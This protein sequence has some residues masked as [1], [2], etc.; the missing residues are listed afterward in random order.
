MFTGTIRRGAVFLPVIWLTG[1]Q[2]PP[3]V[4][5][6]PT[7]A[8]VAP[9]LQGECN[10]C[11]GATAMVTGSMG[12]ATYRFD[13]YDMSDALCG[14]AAAAMDV[15]ALAAAAAKLIKTDISSSG[16]GRPR[17]P[18]APG[19]VL[20][21]WERETLQRWADQPIKGPLPAGNRRP[22]IEVNR[23]PATAKS[24]L[25]FIAT[26][27]DPD[28]DSVIGVVKFGDLSFKMDH[29]GSFAVRFDLTGMAAGPQQLTAVLCDGWGNTAIDLGPISVQK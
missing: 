22:R 17:M 3:Q 13:F 10:H 29:P 27:D 2:G 20:E 28:A 24:Q 26:I 19:P 25:A 9:I 5:T 15:P 4:P 23:L 6:S 8:D 11:H 16:G 1:C 12:P 18:P 21:S 7:W 14:D